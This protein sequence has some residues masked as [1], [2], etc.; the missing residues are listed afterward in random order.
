MSKLKRRKIETISISNFPKDI[1]CKIAENLNYH[2]IINL[3][4]VH[5]IFS[6]NI[7]ENEYFWLNKLMIDYT[8]YTKKA[9]IL[10][11]SKMEDLDSHKARILNKEYKYHEHELKKLE[12][13]EFFLALNYKSKYKFFNDLT[14]LRDYLHKYKLYYY[15]IEYDILRL[16]LSPEFK[17]TFTKLP[18]IPREIGNLVNLRELNLTDNEILEIPKEIGQLINLEKIFLGGNRIDS[19]PKEIGNL[20]KLKELYL[21]NNLIKEI[22]KELKNCCCLKYINLNDNLIPR[23]KSE[24][25]LCCFSFRI[26]C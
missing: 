11:S 20:K 13:D 21:H 12:K 10:K 7:D 23:Q 19:I 15:Q 17:L 22:P 14:N 1:L 4:K 5:I 3:C 9:R 26:F 6:K 18:T 2:D 8:K 16:Y 25:Y 24:E